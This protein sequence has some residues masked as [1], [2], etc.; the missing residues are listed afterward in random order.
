[1]INRLKE[2]IVEAG[3]FGRTPEKRVENYEQLDPENGVS[4]ATGTEA[5]RKIRDYAV[6]RMKE[7]GLEVKI[8]K[9]GNIFGRKEG[10]KSGAGSVMCGSHLDSVHAGI[11][12]ERFFNYFA[13]KTKGYAIKVK[14][15]QVYEDPL[16]LSNFMILF[17][18]QSYMYLH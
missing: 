7:V 4:R 2:N 1:M 17:P 9:I 15:T 16:P 14:S 3:K 12:E 13:N 5:N 8:D 11:N 10:L 6:A 18:P